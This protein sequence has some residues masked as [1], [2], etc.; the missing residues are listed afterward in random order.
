[1][2][3]ATFSETLRM[4]RKRQSMSQ[5]H[6]AS[7]LGVHRNTI[8]TWE[9]GDYLPDS[10]AMVLE[11]AR[12]LHLNEED[13]RALLDASLTTVS[14]SWYVPFPRNPYF[15][16]REDVLHYLA[17]TLHVASGDSQDRY[18]AGL[19]GMGGI[20]KT[21]SALE[22]A[23]R[24]QHAYNAVLWLNAESRE[25]LLASFQHLAR[26]LRLIEQSEP[27]DFNAAVEVAHWLGMHKGWL[28]ILDNVEDVGLLKKYIPNIGRGAV[29][30]T[31][32]LQTL[33]DFAP[34][35]ELQP[36]AIHESLTLLFSRSGLKGP[37]P[38]EMHL[39]QALIRETEG[40]P[41][42]IDQAGA[43]M[44][45]TQCGL[46]TFWT[47]FQ[48]YPLSFLKERNPSLDHP[49]SVVK[50]FQLALA[51]V[52]A[53]DS[54]ACDLLMRCA[55]L[56]PDSIPEELLGR[57]TTIDAALR[58]NQ[59][60]RTLLSYSLLRR[61]P[62]SRTLSIHR[63]VQLVLRHSVDDVERR[64]ILVDSLALVEQRFPV[65]MAEEAYMTRGERLFHQAQTCLDWGEQ[66]GLSDS[67]MASLHAKLA[68]YALAHWQREEALQHWERAITLCEA[69]SGD[70]IETLTSSMSGLATLYMTEGR[71]LKA[72]T[73]FRCVL[74]ALASPAYSEHAYWAFALSGIATI[75]REQGRYQDAEEMFLQALATHEVLR[76]PTHFWTSVT[77]CELAL[78]YLRQRRYE[79]TET[80]LL[81]ACAIWDQPAYH[82]HPYR[83]QGLNALAALYTQQGKHIEEVGAL[84]QEA[85][86]LHRGSWRDSPY[87]DY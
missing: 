7:A 83:A 17:E 57:T 66:E 85:R 10:K 13:T 40:L 52:Q 45:E 16:G 82:D 43:Y 41:L 56:A 8:G 23:Y 35:Y 62:A 4:L 68:W 59:G 61:D 21:Q 70:A 22:Y 36:L 30:V 5:Q 54:H 3:S 84:L 46:E 87:Q 86:H 76:G 37:S 72:E 65:D 24:H 33:G 75:Y 78:L 28:L 20:G 12:L 67:V 50:T 26:A 55:F 77:L 9:R 6:L 74:D 48:Q 2:Q 81:R 47:L 73:Y 51:R 32:R 42:A 58:F 25:A 14:T 63:L 80:L 71:Y 1:M 39:A 79:E 31:T 19:R 29:L 27:S 38:Q 49:S 44:E 53:Q 60:I 11:V 34:C 69:M 15:T 64:S 18:V